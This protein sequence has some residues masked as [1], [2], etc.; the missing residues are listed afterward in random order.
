MG[1]PDSRISRIQGMWRQVEREEDKRVD[2]LRH[3]GYS[4]LNSD[5]VLRIQETYILRFREP[6]QDISKGLRKHK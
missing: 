2:E 6:E 1:I 5:E 4:N 3:V